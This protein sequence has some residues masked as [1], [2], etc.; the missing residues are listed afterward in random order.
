MVQGCYLPFQQADF[1]LPSIFRYSF[2]HFCPPC[3]LC[4][5]HTPLFG[6]NRD[7]GRRRNSLTCLGTSGRTSSQ[8]NFNQVAPTPSLAQVLQELDK[9]PKKLPSR[10]KHAIF[11]SRSPHRDMR[12]LRC[13]FYDFPPRRRLLFAS[14]IHPAGTSGHGSSRAGCS[15]CVVPSETCSRPWR[16]R[17]CTNRLWR[18]VR[19]H[20]P[21]QGMR[22]A[23]ASGRRAALRDPWLPA[24]R[25]TFCH[26]IALR[27][28]VR[29]EHPLLLAAAWWGRMW[30][31]VAIFAASALYCRH[32]LQVWEPPP[33]YS[34]HSYEK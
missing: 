23:H 1:L 24:A 25:V 31:W 6:N 12:L 18:G 3:S 11:S 9:K 10:Q 16:N 28:C 20:G 21:R 7:S 4:A 32:R 13:S 27:V 2:F 30:G 8:K 15:S 17:L 5:L 29:C 33:S 14:M 26:E 19:A 34:P 22:R